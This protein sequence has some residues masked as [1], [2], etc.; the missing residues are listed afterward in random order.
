MYHLLWNG[1]RIGTEISSSSSSSSGS[2][3]AVLTG[4][5]QLDTADMNSS[6]GSSNDLA[7][8]VQQQ[9]SVL[10]LMT[11]EM[12]CATATTGALTEAEA[13][14]TFGGM[15][16][17]LLLA[18]IMSCRTLLQMRQGHTG[19]RQQ[20]QQCIPV[21]EAATASP[22]G[23][24]AEA[25]ALTGAAAAGGMSTRGAAAAGAEV[26]PAAAGVAGMTVASRISRGAVRGALWMFQ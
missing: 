21:A 4:P 3:A 12:Q 15:Q 2:T 11:T 9:R 24:G 8:V 13:G 6:S 19:Q 25:G 20:Q 23:T 17:T 26:C 10:H 18:V 7:A 14:V 5:M 16:P 1:Q 22:L